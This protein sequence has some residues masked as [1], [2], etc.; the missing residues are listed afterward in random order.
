MR[1]TSSILVCLIFLLACNS[2]P[3]QNSVV[4][5]ENSV[6]KTELPKVEA[7]ENKPNTDLKK[8]KTMSD[9]VLKSVTLK[10]QAENTESALIIKYEV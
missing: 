9:Q 5:N 2:Q 6:Q 10:A 7:N 4:I 3:I 8:E 1:V